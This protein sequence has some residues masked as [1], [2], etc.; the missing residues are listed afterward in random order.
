MACR[1]EVV[2]CGDDHRQ[3]TAAAEAALDEISR[4]E[5]LLSR[6]DPASEIARF[7]R[8]PLGKPV[9]LDCDVFGLL[10]LCEEWTRRTRGA[11]DI[12]QGTAACD[13]AP[14]GRALHIEAAQQTA[15]RLKESV[16]LDLGGVGKGYALD[17]ARS[18]LRRA[19]VTAACLH[20]G[21]SSILAWGQP[22]ATDSPH[23][24]TTPRANAPVSVRP[25]SSPGWPIVLRHP[26][27]R[28]RTLATL[29]LHNAGLSSSV[30]DV[31]DGS[32][33]IV[34]P[35]AQKPL[36]VPAGCTVVAET[37]TLAEVVS[38]AMLVL[39]ESAA[40]TFFA[41][42]RRHVEAAWW[43]SRS[44]DDWIAC[45]WSSPAVG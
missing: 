1:C 11:F 28:S 14:D 18:V 5:R 45:S 33:E 7:N 36:T 15:S 39:G 44:H 31:R 32:S 30:Q 2:V 12:T 41:E 25:S 22:P 10:A 42:N 23:A 3:L 34:D 26:E 20:A 38:T 19:G 4:V 16:Q 6:F 21:T 29:T 9:R 40:M 8:S 43:L 24:T 35:R 17:C 27:D 37:A 13:G